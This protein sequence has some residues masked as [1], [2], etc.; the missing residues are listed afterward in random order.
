VQ[1]IHHAQHRTAFQKRLVDQPLMTNVLADIALESEAAAALVFRLARAY[2]GQDDVGES[3]LRRLLTPVAKY[4]ICKRAP[5]LALE[6]MEVLGGNGYI[7]ES[8][9]PRIYREMPVN[10][11]W[12]GSANV[13][14]L[15]VRRAMEKSPEAIDG[16]LAEV[17]SASGANPRLDRFVATL[18]TE[19][20]SAQQTEEG[21]ARR[22]VGRMAVGLQAALLVRHAPP[23]VSDAFC[24]SRLEN[25]AGGTFGMLPAGVDRRAIVD[26]AALT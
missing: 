7:E 24:A 13:I 26:R 23:A 10:S 17:R 6:A 12:E 15:D 22:L 19:L 18:E 16:F 8:I 4:W 2:D 1:A 20:R 11:V 3:A 14:C 9:M 21:L 25:E 5:A